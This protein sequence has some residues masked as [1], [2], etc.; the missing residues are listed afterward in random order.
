MVLIGLTVAAS[1]A[2]AA[3]P[4][5]YRAMTPTF[6]GAAHIGGPLYT[7]A[8]KRA[9][10]LRELYKESRS[11]V[12]GKLGAFRHDPARVILCT[13]T[14]CQR[15]FGFGTRGLALGKQA[16]LLGPKGINAMILTHELVHIH[17]KADVTARDY[18]APRFP[19][20]FDEGLATL[21]SEDPRLTRYAPEDAAW[22]LEAQTFRD[23]RRMTTD[24]TWRDTYGAAQSML[25]EIHTQIGWDGINDIL[26]KT[27]SPRSFQKALE[28]QMG[29]EWP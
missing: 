14:D 26:R 4:T 6:F 18:V 28:A 11:N 20:W 25:R 10:E 15:R 3:V 23:W 8:P 2:Y 19:A 9:E 29:P 13:T 5:P 22:I 16:I 17:I 7:D 1:V 24:D 12:S 21:L 27:T